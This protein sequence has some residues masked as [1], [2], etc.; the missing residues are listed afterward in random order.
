MEVASA[1]HTGSSGRRNMGKVWQKWNECRKL[2]E[3]EEEFLFL[4]QIF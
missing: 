1:S 3:E 4:S 2:K